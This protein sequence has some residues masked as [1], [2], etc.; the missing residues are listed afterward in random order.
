MPSKI[1]LYHEIYLLYTLLYSD[2]HF[3]TVMCQNH[4]DN[5]IR[6]Y[7]SK[8]FGFKHINIHILIFFLNS[9]SL[10]ILSLI[11]GHNTC[12]F[13]FFH[14]QTIGLNKYYHCCLSLSRFH[15]SFLEKT[16]LC[17]K[18][19]LELFLFLSPI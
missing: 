2:P 1:A 18:I 3:G 16:A 4:G 12:L 19:C 10:H 15:A 13:H 5:L 11:H 6:M 7:L 8:Y 17:S 9:I 14:L